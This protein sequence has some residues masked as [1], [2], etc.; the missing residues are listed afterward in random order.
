MM[1]LPW[2]RFYKL[3][4]N[5]TLQFFKLKTMYYIQLQTPT[6]KL[7]LCKSLFKLFEGQQRPFN[8]TWDLQQ[9]ESAFD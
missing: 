5:K 2:Y 1:Y 9:K 4:T 6:L 3:L 8:R 7:S